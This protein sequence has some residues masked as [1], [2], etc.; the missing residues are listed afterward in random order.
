MKNE[1]GKM[2][3]TLRIHFS[4]SKTRY[5]TSSITNFDSEEISE[6]TIEE[7]K[8]AMSQMKSDGA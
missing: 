6:I 2:Y 8:H 7:L 3:S 1:Q 5:Q 4:K